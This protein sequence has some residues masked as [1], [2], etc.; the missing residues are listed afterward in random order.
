MLLLFLML[1]VFLDGICFDT[2]IEFGAND[3]DAFIMIDCEL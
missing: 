1:L 2:I 3:D